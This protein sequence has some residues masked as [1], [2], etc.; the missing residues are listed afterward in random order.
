MKL[1]RQR[2]PLTPFLTQRLQEMTKKTNSR[3]DNAIDT[4][5]SCRTFAFY[6][7]ALSSISIT[8]AHLSIRSFKLPGEIS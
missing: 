7:N 5:I 4:P 8:I 1:D 2:S 3:I 6:Q